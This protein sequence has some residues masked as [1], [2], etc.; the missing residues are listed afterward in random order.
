MTELQKRLCEKLDIKMHNLSDITRKT[1]ISRYWLNCIR[2]EKVVPNYI[3]ISLDD[4]F[5]KL[6]E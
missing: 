4:Y 5:R 3:L 6:G 1:D 2:N